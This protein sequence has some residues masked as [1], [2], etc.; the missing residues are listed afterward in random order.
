MEVSKKVI[1]DPAT[2]AWNNSNGARQNRF[3]NITLL[4]PLTNLAIDAMGA[5]GIVFGAVDIIMDKYGR[6]YVLEI[7]TA[8]GLSN[9]PRH[10]AM[11]A[12]KMMEEAGISEEDEE[13]ESDEDEEEEEEEEAEEQ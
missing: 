4:Q 11:Y 12:H 6:M 2:I 5:C 8:P 3:R 13:E 9:P 7:N 10:V 1:E